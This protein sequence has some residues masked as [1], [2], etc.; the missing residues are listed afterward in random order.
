[1]PVMTTV[2]GFDGTRIPVWYK[3]P[4][5]VEAYA[6][7]WSK[8]IGAGDF[9]IAAAV[10]VPD[11]LVLLSDPPSHTDTVSTCWLSGGV[12]GATYTVTFHV[13]LNSGRQ[14]EA[15]FQLFLGSK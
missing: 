13:T 8:R 12:L 5:E 14:L 10:T 11:G 7:D 3:D 4:D 9:L 15:S 2:R 1:M 6:F